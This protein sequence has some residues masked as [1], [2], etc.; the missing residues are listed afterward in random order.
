M[1]TLFLSF[2]IWAC[3]I[4]NNIRDHRIHLSELSDHRIH[5]AELSEQPAYFESSLP[6]EAFNMLASGYVIS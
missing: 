1:K 4:Q 3:V 5:L 2:L 6:K